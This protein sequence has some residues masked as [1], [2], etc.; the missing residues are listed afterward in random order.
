MSK[1]AAKDQF[2]T[3]LVEQNPQLRD[4]PSFSSKGIRKFFDLIW[5]TAYEHGAVDMYEREEEMVTE[6]TSENI[7]SIL[8]KGGKK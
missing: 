4:Q 2:W 6:S 3:F 1:P 8:F 7:T 5:D